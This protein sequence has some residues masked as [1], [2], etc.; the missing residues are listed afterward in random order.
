M[1]AEGD[2]MVRPPEGLHRLGLGEDGVDPARE[3]LEVAVRPR[4]LRP[5]SP[6]PED[7]GRQLAGLLVTP[8]VV[9][10]IWPAVMVL[11]RVLHGVGLRRVAVAVVA[12][13]VA[14]IVVVV[15]ATAP[16]ATLLLLILLIPPE[17]V[18]V[19]RV[20]AVHVVED[21]VWPVVLLRGVVCRPRLFVL[22]LCRKDGLG[23]ALGVC[24][25]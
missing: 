21:A 5:P 8:C 23:L 11:R 14:A 15:S 19:V 3:Q 20:M 9:L 2:S 24:P 6:P 22:G 25:R 17:L 12:V 7:A 13:V 1:F 16:A 10:L 18:A 4:G